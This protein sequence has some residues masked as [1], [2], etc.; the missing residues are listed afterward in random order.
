MSRAATAIT[1]TDASIEAKCSKKS[2]IVTAVSLPA[3][4][5]DE[6]VAKEGFQHIQ[7]MPENVLEVS[8]GPMRVRDDARQPRVTRTI[9]LIRR[10]AGTFSDETVAKGYSPPSTST[11]R[12]R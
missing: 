12:R 9:A 10:R 1:A 2:V 8:P 3:L 4:C 11:V 5:L 6:L 7:G